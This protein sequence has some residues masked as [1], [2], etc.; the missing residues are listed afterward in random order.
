MYDKL[1]TN[2]GVWTVT[3][4]Q[5]SATA[6][7]AGILIATAGAREGDAVLDD[8]GRV[9][10]IKSLSETEIT[11]AWP[12]KGTTRT[13]DLVIEMRSINRAVNTASSSA[14]WAALTRL[15]NAADLAPNYPVLGRQNAPP[16]GPVDGDRYLV[17][18]V[19]TGAWAGRANHIALWANA[20]AAWQF[21]PPRDGMSVVLLGTSSRLQYNGAAWSLDALGAAG[22]SLSGPLDWAPAVDVAS[23]A[24]VD[25]GAAGS[26]L[27]N[28]TGTVAITALGTAAN[29]VWRLVRF[30]GALT[31][32]HGAALVLPTAAN[33]ATA[34]GD[35]ALFVSRGGGT[36]HCAGYDRADGTPLALGAGSVTTAKLADAAVSNAK[37]A[38]MAAGTIKLRALGAGSGPPVDGTSA[39]A[40]AIVQVIDPIPNMIINGAMQHSQ[41]LGDTAAAVNGSSAWPY[42]CDQFQVIVTGS[43]AAVSAQR[44]AVATPG[45]GNYRTRISVTTAK[46]SL[47]AGDQLLFRQNVEA[48]HFAASKFGTAAARRLL[49]SF[50]FRGPAGIYG[51]SITNNAGNRSWVGTFVISAGQ[52]NIDTIQ[53][54]SVDGATTGEWILTGTAR[55][56]NFTIALACEGANLGLLGWQDGSK[57]SAAGQFNGLSSTA[58]VFEIGDLDLYPDVPGIG[59]VRPF[60]APDPS[61]ELLR[62]QRYC[63]RR[64]EQ[65]EDYS[66]PI[67]STNTYRTMLIGLPV[68]MRIAPTCTA[69]YLTFGGSFASGFPYISTTQSSIR[70]RMDMSANDQYSAL[71]TLMAYSRM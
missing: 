17:G 60:V 1:L 44:V 12:Y 54:I 37:L 63:W 45:G 58:N 13:I 7:V 35:W 71:K 26:N 64:P 46:P 51:W 56:A 31:L 55:G 43:S 20:L 5:G 70:L 67:N 9:L 41:E 25:L 69:T 49:G 47:A 38:D 16:V 10:V 32:T 27:V 14:A 40:R 59:A 21:T 36:W 61:A 52:A 50:L 66:S 19:P 39:Q 34:A 4:T 62:C 48:Q 28:I 33:I 22:G 42:P 8:D 11:L 24:T 53:A 68:E 29:G 3:L 15:L 57:K 23:A 65:G 18:T 6:T 2:P 30:A